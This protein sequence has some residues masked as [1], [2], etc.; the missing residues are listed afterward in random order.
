L[1]DIVPDEPIFDTML[2][3]ALGVNQ[4]KPGRS[5]PSGA[6]LE[7]DARSSAQR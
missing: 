5:R 6:S 7:S 3:D 4:P 1:N 2:G